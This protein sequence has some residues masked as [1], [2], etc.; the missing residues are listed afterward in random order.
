MSDEVEQIKKAAG[1][2]KKYALEARKKFIDFRLRQDTEIRN[3]YI[4][5]ADRL[6]ATI[7]SMPDISNSEQYQKRRLAVFERQL[8]DES[9]ALA[10]DLK[11][12][13][14]KHIAEAVGIGSGYSK[15]VT[16]EL[17]DR[18]NIKLPGIGLMFDKVNKHA[19]EACWARTQDGLFLSDRIWDKSKKAREAIKNI[20]QESVI[21]GQDAVTTARLLERYARTDAKT[22]IKDYPDLADRLKGVPDNLSYEALRLA[23]TE[24]TAAFGEGTIRAARMSPGCKGVKW[25]LSRSHPV[26]DICNALAT[27]D[28]GLGIGVYPLDNVPVYPPHPNCLCTLVPVYM[29]PEDFVGRLKE[30]KAN[31]GNE[32]EIEKWYRNIYSIDGALKEKPEFLK[33]EKSDKQYNDIKDMKLILSELEK[34]KEVHQ[35]LLKKAGVVI[36]TGGDKSRY[37]RAKKIIILARNVKPGEVIHEAAH[38]I[39]TELDLFHNEEFIRVVENGIALEEISLVIGNDIRITDEFEDKIYILD[40][41]D[42]TKFISRYQ[43]RVYRE[44]IDGEGWVSYDGAKPKFNAKCLGEYFSE[45][46]KEYIMNPGNLK[47]KDIILYEFI[48]GMIRK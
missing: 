9:E 30:W 4:K 46:Y 31:P 42:I 26:Y 29:S 22:L 20:I 24:M 23:R 35:D 38:A 19:V 48:E 1:P 21:T 5:F 25:V 10:A 17:L 13:F 16:T 33:I 7:R 2:Y 45:G 3:L 36:K 12:N 37:D 44:D 27:N 32:P 14:E 15:A 41:Q 6:A 28:E 8:R 39:E 43:A 18:A 34:L 11:S 40:R 47:L